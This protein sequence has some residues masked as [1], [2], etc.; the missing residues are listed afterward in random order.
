MGI[1]Y[2]KYS[3]ALR[4]CYRPGRGKNIYMYISSFKWLYKKVN[5]FLLIGNVIYKFS[6]NNLRWDSWV[7]GT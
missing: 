3:P 4:V 2:K 5:N 7:I 1:V 6:G